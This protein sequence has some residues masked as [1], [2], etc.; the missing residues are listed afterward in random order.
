LPKPKRWWR[1]RSHPARGLFREV[2]VVR[3]KNKQQEQAALRR[4]FGRMACAS[5]SGSWHSHSGLDPALHAC[6]PYEHR[7]MQAG[8]QGGGSIL[9]DC[10]LRSP[11]ACRG[12]RGRAAQTWEL[13]GTGCPSDRLSNGEEQLA[14]RQPTAAR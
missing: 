3:C 14:Q 8:K 12:N 11:R 5:K 6:T 7:A 13:P 1:L 10:E 9:C 2:T 4:G